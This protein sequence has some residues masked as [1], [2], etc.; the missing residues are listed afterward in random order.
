M[1][2]YQNPFDET[3]AFFSRKSILQRLLLI[4]V[5]VFLLV[6]IIGLFFW[7]FKATN[8]PENIPEISLFTYFFAVPADFQALIEHPWSIFTYMFL[9]EDFL[10]LLF[11]MIVLYFSGRI[12]MEYLNE[13]KLLT[14]YILGGITGAVFYI[15]AF[16]FFPVFNETKEVSVALGASASVL[17]ILIA[18]ATYVPDYSVILLLFG[19]IKLKYLA[20]IFILIDVLSIKQGNAGGHIAHLGG[21][22]WG[23]LYVIMLKQTNFF[24]FDFGRL[25]NFNRLKKIFSSGKRDSGYNSTSTYERPVSDEE[26]NFQKRKDQEKIDRILEKI[27]KS[28]YG[29]LSK[30]D[31]EL[32]FKSSTK[33]QH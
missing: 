17:A 19:R 3:K 27:S 13:R 6:N 29:S 4:N 8:H 22:F 24:S 1:N 9:H 31:K 26:Y 21:A 2:Y 23:F 15:S 5:A 11:N 28:G 14:T 16:N 18:V 33:N 7:L 10:H 25:I 12:F 32:L 20:L 30:D